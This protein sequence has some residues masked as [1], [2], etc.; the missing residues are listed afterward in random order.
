M[1]TIQAIKARE[2]LDSRGV[3]TIEC[4][5]W[6]DDGHFVTTSVATSSHPGKYEAVEL[7][8]MDPNWMHGKGV[9]QAVDNVNQTIAPQLIG[10]DP[11]KQTEIDQ[12]LINLDGTSNKQKLGANAILVV[13]QA[14]L[15]AGALSVRMPLYYY[16]QQKYQLT[17][18]LDIPSCIFSMFNGGAHGADNLDIKDFQIIPASHLPYPET[19]SMAVSFFRMLDQVL[20]S[21]DAIR[22][23]GLS[24]GFAPNLYYNTDA[25]ELMIETAKATPYTFAQDLF[26][27]VD[28]SSTSFFENNKY[29]LKDKSQPYSAAELLEYYKTMRTTDQVIY[30]EDPF[31]EDD[32]KYWQKITA[33][34]GDTTRIVGD[35]LLVTN[36]QRLREAIEKKACNTASVK[37]NQVGTISESVEYIQIAK[38]AGWQIVISHR[39]GETNDDLLA[40]LAVG[41]GADFCKFG[42]P[43]RGERIAKFNR[44]LEIH[45]EIEQSR[46]QSEMTASTSPAV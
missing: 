2:M 31:Q 43:N 27:G 17:D 13:S 25:F 21:K 39:T 19:L 36:K 32:W 34:L 35:R 22:C 7:L 3:P 26:F 23:V 29:H 37:M 12:L 11:T 45:E 6:L 5:L 28:I 1:G 9:K 20:A 41:V 8:D 38:E 15:K 4:T 16:I 44:L 42:A 33:E 46:I 30:M 40:D 10:K 18:R 14:V 24:G